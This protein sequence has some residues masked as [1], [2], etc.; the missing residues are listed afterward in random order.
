MAWAALKLAALLVV[1]GVGPG[2][3]LVRRLPWSPLEKLCAAFG[4]SFIAVYL[5]GFSFFLLNAPTWAYWAASGLF[6]LMGIAGIGQWRVW[7][8]RRQ[9]RAV[10][11]I[12]LVVLAWEF[13]HLAMV[14]SYNGGNW[15]G[16]WREHYQRSIFFLH[17]LPLHFV[18]P[19]PYIL[20]AR[21]PMMN[22]IAAYFMAQAG[23]HSFEV[24]STVFWFLNGWA[25]MAC[26]LFLRS[27][28]GRW[29]KAAPALAILFM[30]NPSVVE[31]ATLTWTK[32]CTA[33][34]VV[35]GVAF[36]LR[37]LKRGDRSR[38]LAAALSLAAGT[39]V[40]YSAAPFAIAVGLH[41]LTRRRWRETAAATAAAAGLMA[42]WLAWSLRVY[43]TAGT[44][45][46]NTTITAS[47]RRSAWLNVEKIFYNC[48]ATL[49]PFPIHI[50]R[51]YLPLNSWGDLRDY[52]FMIAQ[53]NLT[54][55][56]GISG[57]IIVLVYLWR[58]VLQ[59]RFWLFFLPFI[60]FVGIAVNGNWEP[61]GVAQVTHQPMALMGLAFLASLLADLLPSLFALVIAG[62]CVDYLM[63][64]LL[65]FNR[66]SLT[67][68][69]TATS[70]G[71]TEYLIKVQRG[72]VFWG[73]H[74]SHLL[75]GFQVMSVAGA[76]LAIYFLLRWRRQT[77]PSRGGAP[78]GASIARHD[79][80]GG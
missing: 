14:R 42:T 61:F 6:L 46:S 80:V 51:W 72:Y 23:P 18:F 4:A 1:C 76:V 70:A 54:A 58:P 3:L 52:Y 28:G 56:M 78:A 11:I 73:D 19:G 65:Q 17:Q 31:N 64:I 38:L 49:V 68:P 25:F 57:G 63:G 10:L 33:G 60:Y 36:Y 66:Q 43:G 44:F 79:M 27:L 41:C 74:F 12:W 59:H 24:Y 37:W 8:R 9:S 32:A 26:C 2:S 45:L 75:I 7:L 47:A 13:L 21:P 77:S 39:L 30:L 34:F 20:P 35:M 22:V 16:D 55:M 62:C 50:W 67:Y 71:E 5:A 40:H 53:T 69:V 29:I 48:F 15:C